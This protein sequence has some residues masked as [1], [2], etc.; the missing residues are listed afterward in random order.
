MRFGTSVGSAF[1]RIVQ[2]AE[3]TDLAARVNAALQSLSTE[4]GP[5]G[6]VLGIEIAGAGDGHTF[7]VEIAAQVAAT[8]NPIVLAAGAYA[9][10]PSVV[11]AVCYMAA[12]AGELRIARD[13]AIAAGGVALSFVL[14]EEIAGASK[15]TRFMGLI[16]YNPIIP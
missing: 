15:G 7:I 3:P 10:A 14:T 6:R 2:S 8:F 13:R 16:L 1:I 11:Q 12:D 5:T 9:F 4:L